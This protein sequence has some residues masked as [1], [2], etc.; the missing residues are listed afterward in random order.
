V[1]RASS[2]GR[3]CRSANSTCTGSIASTRATAQR[4]VG[5]HT[6]YDENDERLEAARADANQAAAAAAAGEHH[7]EA[8]QE[9][10][11]Q[12]RSDEHTRS[13]VDRFAAVDH[14]RPCEQVR[15][16]DRHRNREQ[17]LS[18]PCGVAEADQ[19]GDRAHRAEARSLHHR[20]KDN[21]ERER[22]PQHGRSK[23]VNVGVGNRHRQL[24]RRAAGGIGARGCDAAAEARAASTTT[25]LRGRRYLRPRTLSRSSAT[26]ADSVFG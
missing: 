20:S 19:V 4:D 5:R 21:R 15:A 2:A 7:A 14:A 24:A 16:D 12:V 25:P 13:R 8:E 1:A 3:S 11:D 23:R 22:R 6:E 10:A 26:L 9:T 18:H 17:P